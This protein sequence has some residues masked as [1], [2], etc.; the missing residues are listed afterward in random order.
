VRLYGYRTCAS[1]PEIAFRREYVEN[2]KNDFNNDIAAGLCR[3][4]SPAVRDLGQADDTT[5]R[6][7]QNLTY[8]EFDRLRHGELQPAIR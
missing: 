6:R 7:R 1:D 3:D 2:N 8:Q 5:T 4:E